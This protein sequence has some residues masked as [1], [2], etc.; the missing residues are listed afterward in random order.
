MIGFHCIW[1][2]VTAVA[3]V[4]DARRGARSVVRETAIEGF[5]A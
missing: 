1:P 4:G 2:F 3:F 5:S